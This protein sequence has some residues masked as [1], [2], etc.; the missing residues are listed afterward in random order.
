[1]QGALGDKIVWYDTLLMEREAERRKLTKALWVESKVGADK[2]SRE[3]ARQTLQDLAESQ[4]GLLTQG[5]GWG[6]P[7]GPLALSLCPPYA[8]WPNDYYPL[9]IECVYGLMEAA[10]RRPRV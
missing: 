1:M 4:P 6:G 9:H 5:G 10:Y 8:T 3:R 7:P 2:K